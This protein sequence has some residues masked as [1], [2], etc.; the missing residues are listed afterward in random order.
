MQCM[1]IKNDRIES[2]R[3]DSFA[4]KSLCVQSSNDVYTFSAFDR[5]E[6]Y[7]YSSIGVDKSNLCHVRFSIVDVA[8]DYPP[9]CRRLD[10]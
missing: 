2:R 1:K 7:F 4:T 10:A 9:L 8:S 3:A 6:P 5:L